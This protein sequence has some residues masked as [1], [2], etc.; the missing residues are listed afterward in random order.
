M[1]ENPHEFRVKDCAFIPVATGY[2]AQTLTELR[3]RLM[4]IPLASIYYHFWG[5]FLETDF[6]NTEYHNDF[7]F[8]AHSALHDEFLAERLSIVDPSDYENMELLRDDLIDIMSKRLDEIEYLPISRRENQFHFVLSKMIVFDSLYTIAH[9]KDLLQAITSI[10]NTSLF[11]HI[12]DART[13]TPDHSDDFIQWLKS[14]GG[15]YKELI[16]R[17]QKI[18]PYFLNLADIKREYTSAIIDIFVNRSEVTS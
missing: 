13:R 6:K 3:D 11:Y 18:D 16:E 5:R 2:R 17:F 10:P 7:A 1:S 14:F 15:D 9:P 4:T 12:I 8:W